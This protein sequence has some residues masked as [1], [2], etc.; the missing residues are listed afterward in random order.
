[1][2]KYKVLWTLTVKKD[3]VDIIKYISRDSFEIAVEKYEKIKDAA[4]QLYRY[5]E[6][7][8]IIPELLDQNIRKYRE[9]I[10]SPWRLMYKIEVDIVYI[11]A[12]I[13]GRRNI[14]DVLLKRQLR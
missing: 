4:Q 5:P 9:I 10:I 12:V 14:E 8:R 2:K 13:D 7:G 3:L 6:Q 11:M 1:M